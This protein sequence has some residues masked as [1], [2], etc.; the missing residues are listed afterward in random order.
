M[1]AGRIIGT[2]SAL[3]DGYSNYDGVA[4]LAP[5]TVPYVRYSEKGAVWFIGRALAKLLEETGLGK[6]VMV[7]LCQVIRSCRIT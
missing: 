7:C 3:R 2:G 6:G 4:L 1:T 5:V